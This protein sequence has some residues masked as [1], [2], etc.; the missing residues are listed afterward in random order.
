MSLVVSDPHVLWGTPV[1]QG[2]RVPAETL[3]LYLE[4]GESID[5]F[6]HDFPNVSR[7]L[8]LQSLRTAGGALIDVEL[9]ADR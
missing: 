3:F 1:F 5:T 4:E 6:L 9:H 7:E 8:A 2:T